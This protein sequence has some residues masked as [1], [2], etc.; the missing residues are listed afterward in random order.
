MSPNKSIVKSVA[1]KDSTNKL[2]AQRGHSFTEVLVGL[3]RSMRP[4]QWVKNLIAYTPLIFA[5]QITN[6]NLISLVSLCFIAFCLLSSGT[7]ILNDVLDAEADKLHPSKRFRPIASGLVQPGLAL[8]LGILCL[9]AGLCLSFIVRPSLV[10]VACAYLALTISYSL[11][12]KQIAILDVFMIA[13]G[14]VLRAIAGA[15]AA[16]LMPSGWFLLCTS[17]GALF[18]ALEKRRQE[19]RMLGLNSSGHRKALTAY[20]P[21]VLQRM[22]AV[23]VPSL[24]TSYA[25]YG[26]MSIHGEWMLLTVPSVLFGIMRYQ[27]LSNQHFLTATPEEVFWKDRPIQ[28]AIVTWLIAA[29]LVVNGPAKLLPALIRGFDGLF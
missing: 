17:F 23:I 28:L 4:K 5:G 13:A 19:I 3:V 27:M 7:Y 16:Y 2:A 14:F 26:F 22:E 1:A 24:L 25:L 29:A 15:M 21:E 18:L 6:L 11:Y 10:L 12:F 8:G 9:T 20:N